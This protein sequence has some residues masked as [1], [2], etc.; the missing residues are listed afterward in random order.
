MED[1]HDS[2]LALQAKITNSFHNFKS[3]GETNINKGNAESRLDGF[4]RNYITFQV[5]HEKILELEN[6]DKTLA[7]FLT[8]LYDLVED[9]FYDRKENF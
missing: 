9:S 8:F 1:L 3:K 7:Y 2:Q 5:N 4:E 6:L